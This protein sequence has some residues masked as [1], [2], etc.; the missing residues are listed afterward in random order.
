M[1][2]KVVRAADAKCI[3]SPGFLSLSVTTWNFWA[4]LP[5]E[6][7]QMSQ[8]HQRSTRDRTSPRPCPRGPRHMVARTLTLTTQRHR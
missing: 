7:V 8:L 2:R 3:F 6:G 1:L 5:H 4:F